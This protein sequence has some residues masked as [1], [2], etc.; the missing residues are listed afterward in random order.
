VVISH[1]IS[2]TSWLPQ[3]R[4]PGIGGDCRFKVKTR[5]GAVLW[6][7]DFGASP[8]DNDGTTAARGILNDGNLKSPIWLRSPAVTTSRSACTTSVLLLHL[9]TTVPVDDASLLTTEERCH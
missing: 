7:N 5:E 2:Y 3:G 1:G 8:V 4:Y 6:V 9:L